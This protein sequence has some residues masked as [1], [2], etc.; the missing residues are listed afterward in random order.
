[1]DLKHIFYL[2][3]LATATLAGCKHRAA[4]SSVKALDPP[5][6]SSA[7]VPAGDNGT[8]EAVNAGEPSVVST[9]A[10]SNIHPAPTID[11]S[12]AIEVESEVRDADESS[13]QARARW[14]SYSADHRVDDQKALALTTDSSVYN[15]RVAIKDIQTLPRY[16]SNRLPTWSKDQLSAGFA[17]LR[18]GLIK[19]QQPFSA[20]ANRRLTWLYP[21]DGCYSR[22]GMATFFLEGYPRPLNVFLWGQLTVQSE[23]A[24]V[25]KTS[26]TWGYHVAPL[27]Y[28]GESLYVLDPAID[29][30]GPLS[31]DAWISR[32]SSSTD[33]SINICAPGAW[34]PDAE[35]DSDESP[36]VAAYTVLIR[37]SF[38][39]RE[40]NR[41][42]E[43]GRDPRIIFSKMYPDWFQ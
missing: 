28:A 30:S 20:T 42:I 39:N 6:T 14:E 35:C 2:A 21:D 36:V 15:S 40:W 8:A 23:N 29:P 17:A 41:Q 19:V 18:D 27:I 4:D 10:T 12:M 25:G 33:L 11:P 32:Q 43:R 37:G 38:F 3:V 7:Q 5:V 16:R 31:L 24:P 22:A 26:V 13:E 34:N 9:P 1:L